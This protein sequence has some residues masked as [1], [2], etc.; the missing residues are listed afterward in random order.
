V[1]VTFKDTSLIRNQDRAGNVK[2]PARE[3]VADVELHGEQEMTRNS[4]RKY[5]FSFM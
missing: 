4:R 2:Y 1:R 3:L 5:P